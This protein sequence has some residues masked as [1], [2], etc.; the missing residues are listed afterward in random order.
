[1]SVGSSGRPESG[2]V[3]LRAEHSPS[4]DLR[5]AVTVAV[6]AV[7]IDQAYYVVES[8]LPANPALFGSLLVP[9][10]VFGLVPLLSWWEGGPWRDYG[11]R[12]R[13]PVALPIAYSSVFTLIFLIVQLEPGFIFGFGRAPPVSSLTFGFFLSYG[14]VVA[15][16][17]CSVFLGV[18]FRR[19]TGRLSLTRSMLVASAFFAVAATNIAVYPLV[20]F[21][22]A[23]QLLFTTTLTTFVLGLVLAL[24]FY[25]EQWSLLGPMSLQAS[26]LLVTYL[27]PFSAVF[28]SWQDSFVAALMAYAALLVAVAALLKEPRLQAKQYLGSE[29]GPRRFRFRDRAQTWRAARD[30]ALAIT[31]VAVVVAT[32]TVALPEVAG[33]PSTPVLAIATG[34]MVPT[35]ERGTLVLLEKATPDQ[36]H[37]GT[38]IAFHVSCLPAPTVHRVY[39]ILVAGLSPVYLT[40]GDH[41]PSPD[42]CDVPYSHVIGRAVVWVPYLGYLILDPLFAIALIVLAAVSATLVRKPKT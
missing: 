33:T 41:N 34:S 13:G 26:L 11:L 8:H 19:L 10:G 42:P 39:K 28:P 21:N 2:S 35:F 12:L 36:I 7:S 20:G 27:L 1:M 16:S 24:Y 32:S 25:K 4:R 37:V 29:I 31:V 38:I 18:L 9:L 30:T 5:R 3:A 22:L 17:Q 6:I 15:L 14:P 40:K 23:V